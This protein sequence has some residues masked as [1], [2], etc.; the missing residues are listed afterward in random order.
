MAFPDLSD[1]RLR[2]R[3]LLNEST[4]GFFTAAILNRWANDG[5]KDIAIKGL[6]LEDIIAKSNI[7]AVRMLD[8]G[9]DNI[10]KVLGVEYVIA[11]SDNL[12]LLKITPLQLG[13]ID[14]DGATPQYWFPWGHK[15]GIEPK[16]GVATYDLVVYAAIVP[17]D[18]MS[19]DGDEPEIAKQFH[20][21]IV[22]FMHYRGLLREGLFSKAA[23]V[24]ARYIIALQRIRNDTIEKYANTRL[25]TK[26]P[27]RL[28]VAGQE[29]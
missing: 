26:I 1:L 15:I 24:Y 16:P 28:V 3:D 18:D 21:L 25:D 12:G 11:G 7:A 19:A 5:E 17:S 13:R 22:D 29:S 9:S 10:I 4:A 20:E 27:D 23:V 2:A 8:L 6:C 14:L